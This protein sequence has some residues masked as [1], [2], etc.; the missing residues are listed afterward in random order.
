MITVWRVRTN[1]LFITLMNIEFKTEKLRLGLCF[2]VLRSQ[3]FSVLN[4]L[5]IRVIKRV[6]V[7]T[8]NTVIIVKRVFWYFDALVR[9]N[10]AIS[11]EQNHCFISNAKFPL[12]PIVLEGVTLGIL[13]NCFQYI[14][15]VTEPPFVLAWCAWLPKVRAWP[16]NERF[17]E[18]IILDSSRWFLF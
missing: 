10:L 7:C 11:Y 13:Q 16:H 5:F 3:S 12:D 4:S 9:F 15:E 8:N 6:F 14:N 18:I 1:T 2:L 17:C